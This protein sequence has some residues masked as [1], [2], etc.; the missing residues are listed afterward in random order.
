M[1][2][3]SHVLEGFE[4][5][6]MPAPTPKKKSEIEE[7]LEGYFTNNDVWHIDDPALKDFR[8]EKWIINKK[9]SDFTVFQDQKG[10]KEEIKFFFAK[11]LSEKTI[12][13]QTVVVYSSLLKKLKE[14]LQNYYLDISSF[15]ELDP[16]KSLLQWRTFLINEKEC[17]NEKSHCN[18]SFNLSPF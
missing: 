7:F 9:T 2:K 4:K 18:Y 17:F 11:R 12:G 3:E 13:L 5:N 8:P 14:F 1:S 10:I 16:E 15:V 6:Y